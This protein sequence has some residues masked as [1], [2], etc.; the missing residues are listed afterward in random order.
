M[1]Q[2]WMETLEHDTATNPAFAHRMTLMLQQE[3]NRKAAVRRCTE[4]M[5]HYIGAA[6]NARKMALY[7]K[8]LDDR[9]D[10]LPAR[11]QPQAYQDEWILL[12][13]EVHKQMEQGVPPQDPSSQAM[14]QG[15]D[16][17][18]PCARWQ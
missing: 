14:A 9:R 18:V 16:A 1:S 8:Y 5:R 2:R 3:R 13:I 12:F 15:M 7:A 6:F 10:A 11:Q 4:E 17:S